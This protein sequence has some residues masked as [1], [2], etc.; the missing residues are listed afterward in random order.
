MYDVV[1]VDRRKQGSILAAGLQRAAAVDLACREA[2]KRRV[3]R[4]FLAGSE[5][6]PGRAVLIVDSTGAATVAAAA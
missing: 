6:P 4:M 5:P 3:G 2:R 1:Y